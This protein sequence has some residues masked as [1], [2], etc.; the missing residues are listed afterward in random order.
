[1]DT[2]T[3]GPLIRERRESLGLS[4]AEVVRRTGAMFDSAHLF[5]VETGDSLCEP[6]GLAALAT[7]LGL[8]HGDVLRAAAETAAARRRSTTEPSEA[9]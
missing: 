2:T 6:D 7:V 4:K 5:R 9:A 8:D 3:L 1:M